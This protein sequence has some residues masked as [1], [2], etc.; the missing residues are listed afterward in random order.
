MKLPP[1]EKREKNG[2]GSALQVGKLKAFIPHF[3]R[4][5]HRK[6]KRGG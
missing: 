6:E 5:S 4:N 1:S 3:N 2:K